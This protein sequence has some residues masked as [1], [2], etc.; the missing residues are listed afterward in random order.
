MENRTQTIFE[1]EE[2]LYREGS[3][4]LLLGGAITEETKTVF[5]E[6]EGEPEERRERAVTLRLQN[7]DPR[8]I[9]SAYV[10]IH[11]FDRLTREIAVVRDKRYLM[12][13][14]PRDGV[15]GADEPISV[16]ENAESFSV[17]VKKA[18]FEGGEQWTGSGSILFERIP[19]RVPLEEKLTD[20]TVLR[21]FRRDFAQE[22]SGSPRGKALY[23]PDEYKDLWFCACGEINRAEEE[24][25]AACGAPYAAQCE[26]V[27]DEETLRAHHEAREKA[28]AEE[29]ERQRLEAER[30]AAEEKAAAEA[31]ARAAAEAEAAEAARRRKRKRRIIAALSVSIPSLI[32]ICVLVYAYI[33]YFQ[34]KM[35]YD[36]AMTML[37]AGDLDGAEAAFTA[38]DTFGDSRAQLTEVEYR[39]GEAAMEA[40]EYEEAIRHF[41]AVP[42]HEG[43]AENIQEAEYQMAV[44]VMEAG[45]WEGALEAFAP[46]GEYKDLP[47][48]T[49]ACNYEIAMQALEEGGLDEA[50]RYRDLLSEA[51]QAELEKRICEKGIA[52]Y[53]AGSEA[54]AEKYFAE[55][56]DKALLETVQDARYERGEVLL[57]DGDLDGAEAI[58]TA[59][60]GYKESAGALTEISYRRAQ[61]LEKA[62]DYAAALEAYRALGTYKDAGDKIVEVAYELGVQQLENGDVYDA[63]DTLYAI[64]THYDAY[65]LL[66]TNSQFYIY[67]YDPGVGPNP[68]YEDIE[69]TS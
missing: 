16:P 25:C 17:A 39:R 62:G 65:L 7:L 6:E 28:I 36:R 4:V 52:L 5:P 12:P 34:P 14:L 44:A 53:R 59:L 55:V 58:F 9:S 11:V 21:Q 45:N 32:A 19:D 47:E 60:D 15:F 8:P 66:I 3:P 46:L 38:L 57:E 33:H 48:R 42:S 30:K 1:L 43:S 13:F 50:L 69:F 54:E 40:G 20:E 22:L 41:E 35:E 67:I 27:E 10:D 61:A 63:Y 26:L 49:E 56:K 51:H 2:N 23:V 29:A 31:R 64:R 24:K 68:N 37:E 18:E